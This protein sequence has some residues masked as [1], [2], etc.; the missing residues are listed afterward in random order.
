MLRNRLR[1]HLLTPVSS[2]I[3]ESEIPWRDIE[4]A[5]FFGVI[6]YMTADHRWEG[7][8]EGMFNS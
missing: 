6:G 7:A 4:R 2:Q 1:E 3:S 8:L 5:Q